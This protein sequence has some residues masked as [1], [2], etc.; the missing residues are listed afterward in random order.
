M[1]QNPVIETDVAIIGAGTAGMSAYRAALEHT[2]RVL[3]IESGVYGTT[4]ARVGCMPSKLLIAAADAAHGIDTAGR[5]GVHGGPLRVDV[6]ARFQEKLDLYGDDP[7]ACVAIRDRMAKA[8][9]LQMMV[10]KITGADMETL[11]AGVLA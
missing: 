11:L 2:P 9:G 8:L 10:E 6:R 7:D 1:N 5:F 4:C 3:V